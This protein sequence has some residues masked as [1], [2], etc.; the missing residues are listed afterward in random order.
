M[1]K[2][3]IIKNLSLECGLTRDEILFIIDGFLNKIKDCVHN[4]DQVEIR[5]FGTF[6]KTEKRARKIHSPIAGKIVD[7]PAKSIM[8]F[9]ASKV[10]EKNMNNKGV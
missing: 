9:K 10:I 4:N 1:N 5:G 3:E 7:V 6:L 8:G 2:S